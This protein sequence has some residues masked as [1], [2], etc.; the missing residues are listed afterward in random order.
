MDGLLPYFTHLEVILLFA[1]SKF[2]IHHK[3]T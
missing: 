3:L 2:N 1:K